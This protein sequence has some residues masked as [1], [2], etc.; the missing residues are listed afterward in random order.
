GESV[1][2]TA[3]VAASPPGSGTP[4]G[5]VEF[6]D[7]ATSLGTQPLSGGSTMLVTSGLPLGS[8]SITA[9]YLGSSDFGGSTSAAH[10]HVVNASATATSVA[11]SP[12]PSAVGESVT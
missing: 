6:F 12:N 3:S 10:S 5:S 9:V 2:L 11:S 8:P 7:G 4:T 1:T